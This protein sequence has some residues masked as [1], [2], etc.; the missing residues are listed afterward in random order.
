[1]VIAHQGGNSLRPGDTL[2][3]FDHAVALGVD[4]LQ[5]EVHLSRDQQVVVIHDD[6]VDRTTD[7]AGA[8]AD[9]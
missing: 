1:M 9:S 7:G 8:V 2:L 3:A 5:M 4:V 6:T